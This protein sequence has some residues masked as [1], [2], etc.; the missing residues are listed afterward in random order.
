[1]NTR[2][3]FLKGAGLACAG[4]LALRGD[5]GTVIG[6]KKI[7]VGVQLYSF[8]K[9]GEKD[10]AGI[11]KKAAEIGFSGKG[12]SP[13]ILSLSLSFDLPHGLSSIESGSVLLIRSRDAPCEG[14]LQAN[15]HEPWYCF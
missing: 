13:N 8:R 11:I 5:A 15:S 1:M 7:P 12:V 4:L 10:F 9:Q 6:S 3:S 14:V 2:R